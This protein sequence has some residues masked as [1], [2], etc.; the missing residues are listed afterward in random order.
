MATTKEYGFGESDFARGWFMIGTSSDATKVPL[1]IRYFGKDLVVY[2][3][4]SGAPYVVDAYCP[5][6]GAH[7][8]RNT[9]SCI[10]L[11][12]QHVSGESIRSP[13]WMWRAPTA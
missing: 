9:T 13:P 1:P 10:V 4:E 8:A 3:G 2:R 12:G 5:H 11:D 7:I 6:M